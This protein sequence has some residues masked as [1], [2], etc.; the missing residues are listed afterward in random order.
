MSTLVVVDYEEPFNADEALLKLC[1]LQ[2]E[3]LLDLE[4]ATVA[5]K[6]QQ[7][8]VKLHHNVNPTADGCDPW[9]LLGI[10]HW[11]DFPAIT[12]ALTDLGIHDDL[13]KAL[14]ATMTPASSTRFAL[15]DL[16]PSLTSTKQFRSSNVRCRMFGC[17]AGEGP[18]S[19]RI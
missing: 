9:R 6:D 4:D 7:R 5:I 10:G 16:L 11:P 13:M 8:K 19:A 3:Y 14:A 12:G 1:K 18:I 15:H 17:G 2:R